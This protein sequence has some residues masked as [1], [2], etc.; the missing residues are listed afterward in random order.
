M[1]PFWNNDV[2][3]AFFDEQLKNSESTLNLTTAKK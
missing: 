2:T 3:E 1:L